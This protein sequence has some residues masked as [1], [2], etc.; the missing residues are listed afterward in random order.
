MIALTII[1]VATVTLT[2][3][4]YELVIKHLG[5]LRFLIGLKPPSQFQNVGS[6]G[7]RSMP[8]VGQRPDDQDDGGVAEPVGQR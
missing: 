8:D 5:M 6:T 1:V 4:L 2:L 3:G 7:T